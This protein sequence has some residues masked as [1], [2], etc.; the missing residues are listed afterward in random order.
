MASRE[1]SPKGRPSEKYGVSHGTK[2]VPSFIKRNRANLSKNVPLATDPLGQ[3]AN[4]QHQSPASHRPAATSTAAD[5]SLSTLDAS[6]RSMDM[7][8]VSAHR[9]RY[10]ASPWAAT[11]SGMRPKTADPY[12]GMDRQMGR[13]AVR[14]PVRESSFLTPVSAAR[15][16]RSGRDLDQEFGLGQASVSP[17]ADSIDESGPGVAAQRSS[18]YSGPPGAGMAEHDE[19]KRETSFR[20]NPPPPAVKRTPSFAARIMSQS[21][22]EEDDDFDESSTSFSASF[23]PRASVGTRQQSMM[24]VDSRALMNRSSSVN[25]FSPEGSPG[26]ETL[27]RL[28]NEEDLRKLIENIQRGLGPQDLNLRAQLD[29]KMARLT[30]VLLDAVGSCDNVQVRPC[31]TVGALIDGLM[32]A[33]GFQALNLGY[34]TIVDTLSSR[35]AQA[36]SVNHS[37]TT[38]HLGSIGLSEASCVRLV[39]ALR[40]NASGRVKQLFLGRNKAGRQTAETLAE[41]ISCG[42]GGLAHLQV[43]SLSNNRIGDDGGAALCD[44]LLSNRHMRALD[45]GSNMLGAKTCT[46]LAVSLRENAALREMRIERNPDLETER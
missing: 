38:L 22:Y 3:A 25:L 46:A 27:T 4:R 8:D 34:N 1:G 41:A 33:C 24:R 45:V 9:R 20:G 32:R 5:T 31:R 28:V 21:K 26:K 16:L 39:K 7:S 23:K 6:D 18:R 19:R 11:S 10:V 12:L 14:K 15:A 13:P 17:G 36:F 44:A 37:L 35:L 30:P 43:L 40:G 2:Q 29:A 42:E